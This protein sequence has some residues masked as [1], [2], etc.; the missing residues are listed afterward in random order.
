[1]KN[2]PRGSYRNSRSRC[3]ITTRRREI[4]GEQEIKVGAKEGGS[5]SCQ[6]TTSAK[7][8]KR[9]HEKAKEKAK[10]I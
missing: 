1:M 8:G 6:F 10:L 9:D 3:K 2:R 7:R 5:D 4:G